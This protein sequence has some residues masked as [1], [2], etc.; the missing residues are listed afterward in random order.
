MTTPTWKDEENS[1]KYQES[2]LVAKCVFGIVAVICATILV[3]KLL[4]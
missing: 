4:P 2:L 1:R 3:W